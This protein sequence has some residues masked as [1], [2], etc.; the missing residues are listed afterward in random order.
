MLVRAPLSCTIVA[1]TSNLIAAILSFSLA[2]HMF[3]HRRLSALAGR[4]LPYNLSIDHQMLGGGGINRRQF[5]T[6][7]TVH[8]R[9]R[10][11]YRELLQHPFHAEQR[12]AG[13]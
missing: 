13:Q 3:H 2:S 8:R 7:V 6:Q 1:V 11:G 10:E 9:L 5:M 4:W 12:A